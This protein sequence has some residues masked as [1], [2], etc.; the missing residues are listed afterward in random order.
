MTARELLKT[1]INNIYDQEFRIV[2]I[3][4]ID[5]FERKHRRQQRI[6]CCT[7]QGTKK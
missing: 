4:L 1:D 3:K 5:G 6:Y 2:V 7:D